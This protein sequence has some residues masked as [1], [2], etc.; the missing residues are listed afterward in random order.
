MELA[1]LARRQGGAFTRAQARDAGLSDDQI[2]RRLAERRWS[3]LANGVLVEAATPL[4]RST[5]LWTCVLAA[6]PGA[7][8][9]SLSA[10]WLW[11]WAADDGL[12]HLVVP[13]GRRRRLPAEARPR[14]TAVDASAVV[15]L[16]GLPVTN[17]VWTLADCL[18]QLPRSRAAEVLDRSQQRGAPSLLQVAAA[19]PARGAG[20]A[21]ARALLRAA[22]GSRFEAE[23]RF[24]QLL[25]RA[26]IDGWVANHPVRV[27]GRRFVLDVAF[28]DLHIVIEIDG[29]AY[30]HDPVRFQ[31]DRQRQ[32]LLV[33]AGWLVL[34]F[35]WHDLVERPDVVV[36]EVQAAI[37]RRESM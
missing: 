33:G 19:L 22:D 6:G 12:V 20:S 30:H 36:A 24:L 35:T 31:R 14:R 7:A 27:A 28:P 16:R 9:A 18:R 34:R 15:R 10:A 13:P 2:D 23:R 37:R 17:Q 5:Q 21:Q 32:N 1:S 26:G 29:F 3:R 4:T 11:G 25:R 8:I